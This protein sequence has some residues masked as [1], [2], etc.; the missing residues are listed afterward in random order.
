MSTE[1]VL[2]VGAITLRDNDTSEPND[3]NNACWAKSVEIADYTVVNGGAATNVGAFV[4]WNIRVETLSVSCSLF[5]V[6][7]TNAHRG[8]GE[9]HERPQALL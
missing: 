9:L 2:P 4:V 1:S 8:L 7:R 5:F 6:L 3:R